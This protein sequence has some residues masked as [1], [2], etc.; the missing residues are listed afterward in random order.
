MAN[1]VMQLKDSNNDNIFPAPMPP[2][3]QF[4]KV[5]A[6]YPASGTYTFNPGGPWYPTVVIPEGYVAIMYGPT[7]T[8]G[9]IGSAYINAFEGFLGAT[10][11]ISNYFSFWVLN[12][13]TGYLTCPIL[14]A[15]NT[16]V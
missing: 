6:R 11:D 13:G 9:F 7:S 15:K 4:L 3:Q 5:E 10:G 2:T 8:N 16:T 14:C 12:G 1:K